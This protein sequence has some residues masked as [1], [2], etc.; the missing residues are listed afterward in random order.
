M[1]IANTLL[2]AISL[3]LIIP[4]ATAC[5]ENDSREIARKTTA[6]EYADS[7]KRPVTVKD[8]L[9]T[10]SVRPRISKDYCPP[11]GRG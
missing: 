7:L 4:A 2:Q 8:T 9:K 5:T 1:K 11:C 6:H 10:D 3:A